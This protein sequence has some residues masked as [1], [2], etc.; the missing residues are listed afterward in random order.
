[1]AIMVP[2]ILQN[3]LRMLPLQWYALLVNL[4]SYGAP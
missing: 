2:L 4:L 1:M 3:D